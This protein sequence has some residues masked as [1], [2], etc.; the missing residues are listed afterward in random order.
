MEQDIENGETRPLLAPFESKEEKVLG[1]T[2][3]N[4]DSTDGT[5]QTD[6]GAPTSEN[7]DSVTPCDSEDSDENGEPPK[8]DAEA[9]SELPKVVAPVK[10]ERIAR[11]DNYKFFLFLA[12]A[13]GHASIPFDGAAQGMQP[14][15]YE[16]SRSIG[17][18]I[19]SFVM[20]GFIFVCGLVASNPFTLFERKKLLN[21]ASLAVTLVIAN[22]LYCAVCSIPW[23][24][25]HNIYKNGFVTPINIRNVMFRT[26]Y[27]M[28]FISGLLFWRI[29]SPFYAALLPQLMLPA[30]VATGVLATY[31]TEANS[32][33][34]CLPF[35]MLGV[36]LKM[37]NHTSYINK[38]A[39]RWNIKSI[40][41][42]WL[43]VNFSLCAWLSQVTYPFNE[44]TNPPVGGE[45]DAL[46]TWFT[47]SDKF[48]DL[49]VTIP[50]EREASMDDYLA[51]AWL[52]KLLVYFV[53]TANIL[54]L[55]SLVP[56]A[57]SWITGCG[58]RT[59]VAY[60]FHMFPI[61]ALAASGWYDGCIALVT[62]HDMSDNWSTCFVRQIGAETFAI[63][64]ALALMSKVAA[65]ALWFIVKPP[66]ECLFK[67]S[68]E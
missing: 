32:G 36:Y 52:Y 40:A 1:L 47:H 34:Q 65:A 3:N 41:V 11:L 39:D 23:M 38:L 57:N 30:A 31:M 62:D 50:W 7:S 42:M 54:A 64:V 19:E 59:I 20:P 14:P 37:Y 49:K 56:A 26:Q 63:L 6:S 15:G 53:Q 43:L 16:P 4:N 45:Y 29:A 46:T 58:T 18:M 51:R 66:I 17:M 8:P 44:Y 48:S 5:M 55:F 22:F 9:Q 60:V 25:K 27:H 61:L 13:F 68:L 35:Y 2:T 28:W 12:V 10:E 33:F 21:T 24:E 67:E